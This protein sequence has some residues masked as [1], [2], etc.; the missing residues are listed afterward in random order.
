MR[1]YAL[2]SMILLATLC[3]LPMSAQLAAPPPA[4]YDG[5]CQI[6]TFSPKK[7]TGGVTASMA[8]S[9]NGRFV[10]KVTASVRF[11]PNYG[12]PGVFLADASYGRVTQQAREYISMPARTLCA[13]DS[14]SYLKFCDSSPA[15]TTAPSTL[16][17]LRDPRSGRMYCA[18][19]SNISVT[20]S[21]GGAATAAPVALNPVGAPSTV[22]G[23]YPAVPKSGS[24]YTS[25]TKTDCAT[26]IATLTW[27]APGTYAW[28][29]PVVKSQVIAVK[30]AGCI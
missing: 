28:S 20:T 13:V 22:A 14:V 24:L 18:N 10:D 9:C 4:S 2:T 1:K 3:S 30:P 29:A 21:T 11:D 26:A 16:T 6:T 15:T 8:F 25:S 27:D 12:K 23:S 7:T 5:S 19:W 17:C